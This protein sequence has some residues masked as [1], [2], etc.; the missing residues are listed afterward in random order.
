MLSQRGVLNLGHTLQYMR[1]IERRVNANRLNGI[2][3]R[4]LNAD[5]VKE[6]C[7]IIN[8][9]KNSRYPVMRA[10][11]QERGGV[12]R[13]DAVAWG[14]ARGASDLGVDIIQNC[15]VQEFKLHKDGSVSG[16]KTSQGDVLAKKVAIC[17]AG[18]SSVLAQKAGFRLPIESKSLQAFVSEPIKPILNTVVMSNHVHAYVSQTDKGDVVIGA[19]VDAYNGYGQ[20]GSPHVVE[21]SVAAVL[22]LF[23]MF[24]RL[25]MNRQWGGVVDV[26]P[27]ACPIV[28]LTPV[29]NLFINC[30]WGTGGFKGTPGC[31]HVF[32]HTIATGQPHEINEPFSLNRFIDGAQIVN[33]NKGI[34]PTP[35]QGHVTSSY[36]SAIGKQSIAMA[37]IKNGFNRYD[38]TVYAAL[39]NGSFI[40]AKI[41]KPVFY[42][43]KG[44]RQNV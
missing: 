3:S 33:D 6:V 39:A 14:F 40:E 17:V 30:G 42:D 32:A 31:G 15:E 5:E 8:L 36:Y 22:E 1:D 43:P 28:G 12:A 24:S 41:T 27:D 37:L 2:D 9:S 26:S 4:V 44:E 38:Q 23:P 34:I 16:L 7:P 21:Q 13:H 25:K 10:F 19:G 11:Y 18:N 35:M 29:K 20:R